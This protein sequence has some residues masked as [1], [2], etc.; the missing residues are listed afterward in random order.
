MVSIASRNR[1]R[2]ASRCGSIFRDFGAIFGGFGRPKSI[3]G[4]IFF[5]AFF[6]C[7]FASIF[8]GFWEAWNLKNQ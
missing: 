4:K 3:F 8:C 7:V 5:D 2:S 1:L 6:E